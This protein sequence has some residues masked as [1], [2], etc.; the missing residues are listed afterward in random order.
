MNSGRNFS[1]LTVCYNNQCKN[2]KC[3]SKCQIV[4]HWRKVKA[5]FKIIIVGFH[6]LLSLYDDDV[7]E[8]YSVISFT[9]QIPFITGDAVYYKP[10][11][12]DNPL[13]GLEEGIYYVKSIQIF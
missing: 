13:V 3:Y 5:F 6:G 7:T 2:R 8:K 12:T 11:N 9:T 4:H 10:D 1:D